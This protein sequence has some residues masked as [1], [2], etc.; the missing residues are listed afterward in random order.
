[1]RD[2]MCVSRPGLRKPVDL[3]HAVQ[4]AQNEKDDREND[5]DDSHVM[6]PL[7]ARMRQII[8]TT[9]QYQPNGR[10]SLD[11]KYRVRKATDRYAATPAAIPPATAW[12]STT[13][14]WGAK[15]LGISSSAAAKITGVARRNENRAACS[16]SR[17]KSNPATI[18]MPDREIPGSSANDC[19][20][21]IARLAG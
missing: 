15:S 8:P 1:M 13:W 3:P 14:A 4:N 17:S 6:I 12:T 21:P 10:R 11:L 18:E 7:C 9:T 2:V 5:G 20:T 19:A 16:W